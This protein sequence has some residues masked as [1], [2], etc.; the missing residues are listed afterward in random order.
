[1]P[2]VRDSHARSNRLVGM[3]PFRRC[4]RNPASSYFADDRLPDEISGQLRRIDWQAGARQRPDIVFNVQ[5]Q[6]PLLECLYS[7]AR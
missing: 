4:G 6:T 1:V 3:P 7:S 2:F 5:S